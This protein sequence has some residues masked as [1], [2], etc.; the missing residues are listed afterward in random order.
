MTDN[1]KETRGYLRGVEDFHN[2][3]FENPFPKTSMSYKYYRIAQVD[4]LE[5]FAKEVQD[6][7]HV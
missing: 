5:I 3:I 6:G 7:R 1:L 2:E 4:E